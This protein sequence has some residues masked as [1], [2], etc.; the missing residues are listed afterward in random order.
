MELTIDELKALAYPQVTD[1]ATFNAPI[2]ASAFGQSVIVRSRDSGVW[3]GTLARVIGAD[4]TL[5]RARRVWSWRGA[6]ELT[7][8]ARDGVNHSHA[9]TRIG[10][11][12]PVVHVFG[13]CEII[14]ASGVCV[15]S[16]GKVSEWT[17]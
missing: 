4:V 12:T 5:D 15:E 1:P 14:P 10:V 2:G 3:I 8:L 7:Q 17:K 13:I 16:V 6:A 9:D 11:T